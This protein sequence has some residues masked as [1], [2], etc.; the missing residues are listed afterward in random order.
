MVPA[1]DVHSGPA[2]RMAAAMMPAATA[3]G[4]T[5]A[6]TSTMAAATHGVAA[7]MTSTASAVTAP[8]F[9]KCEG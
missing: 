7:A 3:D 6:M 2:Y 4:M 1:A 5:A 9:A 8:G